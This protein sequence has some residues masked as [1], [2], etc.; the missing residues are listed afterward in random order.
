MFLYLKKIRNPKKSNNNR[1]SRNIETSTS[2]R[3]KIDKTSN[4]HLKNII[5]S[6]FSDDLN[7]I[8]K[9]R[10]QNSASD[11]TGLSVKN[12]SENKT[13]NNNSSS[14]LN[15]RRSSSTS[16]LNEKDDYDDDDP[17]QDYYNGEYLKKFRRQLSLD[18]TEKT[19]TNNLDN[20][21]TD[22]TNQKIQSNDIN[23]SNDYSSD[24]SKSDESDKESNA[25]LYAIDE[26]DEL[27][28]T[29]DQ[30]SKKKFRNEKKKKILFNKI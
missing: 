8:S 5:R 19:K 23:E 30:S 1:F 14:R 26:C 13:E 4:W 27:I 22:E 21:V 25:D 2:I 20:L 15:K 10:R 7:F 11:L 6:E 16:Y 18:E 9:L 3:V 29:Y 24:D 17:N 12:S 28:Q